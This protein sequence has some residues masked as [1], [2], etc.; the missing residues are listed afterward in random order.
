[1]TVLGPYYGQHARR[2]ELDSDAD[3][4]MD[5]LQACADRRLRLLREVFDYLSPCSAPE[6]DC[7]GRR[8]LAELE[9]SHGH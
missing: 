7:V 9:A 4:E 6:C 2:S 1:V 8:V 5:A 3:I